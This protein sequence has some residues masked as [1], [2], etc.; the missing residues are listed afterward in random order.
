MPNCQ[1]CGIP[2]ELLSLLR[3]Q[4]VILEYNDRFII[5]CY[6]ESNMSD[7][8][9]PENPQLNA[10]HKSSAR[11]SSSVGVGNKEAWVMDQTEVP[12]R[13]ED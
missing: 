4:I 11:R 2:V 8:I 12:K 3:K 10:K 6:H 7:D 9:K 13:P 5:S 1:H